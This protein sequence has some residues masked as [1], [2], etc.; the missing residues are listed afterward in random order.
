ME[1]ITSFQ[2]DLGNVLLDERGQWPQWRSKYGVAAAGE[3]E[4]YA[5]GT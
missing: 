5:G 3:L 2:S 4:A 1:G